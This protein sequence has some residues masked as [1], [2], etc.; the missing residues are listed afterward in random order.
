MGSGD[1]FDDSF[2]FGLSVCSRLDPS[3]LVLNRFAIL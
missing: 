3:C 2:E 1:V